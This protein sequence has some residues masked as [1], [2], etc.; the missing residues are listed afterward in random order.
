[1]VGHGGC[2]MSLDMPTFQRA[3]RVAAGLALLASVAH[4]QSWN[5]RPPCEAYSESSAV[6]VGIAG[7]PVSRRV[8]LPEHPPLAM[9]LT[10]FTVERAYLGVT[11]PVVYA[12]PRGTERYATP[13]G[14]Y[15]IYGAL[16]HPP[17][18]V[19]A[20][21]GIG[22]EP[23]DGAADD[24]AFLESL[25]PGAT[26]GTINGIVE[27]ANVSYDRENALFSPIEGTHVRIFNDDYSAEVVTG[28]DGRFVAAGVPEGRYQIVPQLAEDVVVRDPTSR[29]QTGVRDGGCATVRIEARFNGRLRGVLRGPDGVP[30]QSTS[31]DIMPV[32]NQPQPRSGH[33][34]GT[35]SVW[36]NERGEFEFS[37][38]PPGRYY[39]GVSLYNAPNPNGPS[40]PRTYYPG[41]A[42][43]ESAVPIVVEHGRPS[44][45]FDL[46]VP[47][48]LSK[49]ELEAIVERAR[50]GL[51]KI[52][53]VPLEN[54][55]KIWSTWPARPGVPLRRP[56]VDGQRYEIHAHVE[57]PGG[58][59]ESEPFVF[60]ATT[61]KTVVRLRPDAPR[62][63]H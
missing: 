56:V 10:P 59:L 39:L 33:I 1:M 22:A 17:D 23:I 44:G 48:V 57:F 2:L 8:Q 46:V 63:L 42:D 21:P 34:K 16:Y 52:C 20:S 28:A 50:P 32:D 45:G 55:F 18:I 4:A 58:H 62:T 61:V 25:T 37:G 12:T 9:K 40:Y 15:L 53:I 51:L 47:S 38:M 36:T 26:G 11:T 27:L 29:I 30:L 7:E 19:M 5:S 31:V 43:R 49:G 3:L 13:G 54:L 41:T 14:R 24:L 6:F 35:G 60:T